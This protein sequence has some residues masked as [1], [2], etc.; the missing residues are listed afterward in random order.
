MRRPSPVRRL[1]LTAG[2][3]LAVLAGSAAMAGADQSDLELAVKASYLYKL[4]PFVVWPASAPAASARTFV[5][6]VQGD[7]SFA[8]LVQ[9]A[10]EGQQFGGRAFEV[11]RLARV[12]AGSGCQIA[13]LTG[14]PTQPLP[15]AVRALDGTSVLTVTDEAGE[16]RARGVIHLVRIDGRVRFDIDDVAAERDGLAI[17][18]KLLKLAV[19]VRTR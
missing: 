2:G 3:M 7:Q 13:Y 4:A 16:G 11:R 9:R 15:Q 19:H 17:S 12:E 5:I 6:C 8:D 18:S 1:A 10:V 14:S